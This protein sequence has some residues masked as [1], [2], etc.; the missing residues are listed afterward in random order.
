MVEGI[1]PQEAVDRLSVFQS[2]F[3]EL[4]RQYDT[5]GGGEQLFGLPQTEYPM[6]VRTKKELGL[7]QKLY[8]L[9]TAV[10][11]SISGYF[12][13]LWTEVDIEK[14]NGELLDFQNRLR[15]YHIYGFS[16][17]LVMFAVDICT[18]NYKNH[19]KGYVG[20]LFLFC[21]KGQLISRQFSNTSN[22]FEHI[23]TKDILF[24]LLVMK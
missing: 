4:W 7:L 22:T 6:L 10:M 16:I 23:N 12:D 8:G 11:D 15:I 20:Q 9:Y 21:L 2:K 1:S 13:I 14:I 17:I 3:D 19:N 5:Y 18:V 24:T